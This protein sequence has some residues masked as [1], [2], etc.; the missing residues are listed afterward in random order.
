MELLLNHWHRTLSICIGT[1]KSL[2]GGCREVRE[3]MLYV[4]FNIP[5]GHNSWSSG[6]KASI[7]KDLF[8]KTIFPAA[9]TQLEYNHMETMKKCIFH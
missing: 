4:F 8:F 7:L 5:A 2:I 6:S 9:K 1:F 3:L